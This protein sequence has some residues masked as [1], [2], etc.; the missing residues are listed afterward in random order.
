MGN[1][2]NNKNNKNMKY[3]SAMVGIVM[4]YILIS[5]LAN[6]NILSRQFKSLIVPVG[7][8]IILAVSLNLTVGFLGEL[9]LGHAGFMAIGAYAS[10]LF[11]LNMD[12][13]EPTRFLISIV[14]AGVVAGVFGYLVEIGR[15]HV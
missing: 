13:H 1:K 9:S 14:I 2:M 5:F 11:T 7:I 15:A 10:A 8:N 4:I 3:I 6:G 12:F